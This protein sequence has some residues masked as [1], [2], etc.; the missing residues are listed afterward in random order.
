M[1][2]RGTDV[3]L[4]IIT[5][6]Y[7]SA[8]YLR[9]FY[10]RMRTAAEAVGDDFEI[11]FVNDGSPDDSQEIAQAICDEDPRCR[12]IELSRNFGHHK[13][14]MT[15]LAHAQGELI[16][17]IDCDLEEEPEWLIPF[18]GVLEGEEADVVYGVQEHRKGGILE[19]VSGELFYRILGLVSGV[20]IPRN[21]VTTRLMRARYVE[22]LVAHQDR[23][24]FLAGL[25]AITGFRQVPY[26]VRK[27][28]KGCSAY[29]FPRKLA[30]TVNAITSFSAKPLYW[31][32]VLGMVIVFVST[33]SAIT[34]VLQKLIYNQVL[35][36]WTSLIV[37]I[38]FLGGVAIFCIGI[39][40]IYVAK[41][42]SEVK[43]RP[44]TSVRSY[45]ARESKS[46]RQRSPQF[47]ARAG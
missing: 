41:I 2:R 3:E 26:G 11:I 21:V 19:R 34:L 18:K 4:S 32:F 16:F 44:Y 1:D 7:Q 33:C 10:E 23:E 46:A 37:S 9:L 28:S 15:G 35:S 45:Y 25:W 5:T 38:W 47:R 40:G 31:I 22:E 8:A 12:V 20:P 43:Q 27:G 13:A 36:G 24:V 29:N 39:V 30:I 6:M 42:Y 17:L 14:M